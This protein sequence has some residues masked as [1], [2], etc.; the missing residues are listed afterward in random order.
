MALIERA[1]LT[2]GST[3]HAAAGFHAL[4]GDP[5]IAVLQDYTINLYREIEKES[6]VNC[7]LHMTGG[8]NIATDPDRWEQ[9]KAGWATFQAIGVT[10]AR[11][12]S[13]NEVNEI[14]GGVVKTSDVLGG[15]YDD[16]EGYLD[17]NG[18][19]HAYVGACLLYTSD[20]ADE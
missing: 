7:G 15:L 8:V 14:T 20:A 17:P 3:W 18:T 9:I 4:N 2:A 11:L 5:N 13:P 16:N 12:M 10:T 1:E 19:T 6:G